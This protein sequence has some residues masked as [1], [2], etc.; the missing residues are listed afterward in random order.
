MA[1]TV[2]ANAKPA[3][4]A[5]GTLPWTLGAITAGRFDQV[6]NPHAMAYLHLQ[7]ND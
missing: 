6:M 7:N 4:P 5:C 2:M 1:S 3:N